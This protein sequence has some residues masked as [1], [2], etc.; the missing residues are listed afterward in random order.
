MA[1]RRIHPKARADLDAIWSYIA[2]DT[3]KSADAVIAQITAAFE[4]LT[5]N[6][7]A[8][9]PRPELSVSVRSFPV[10]SHVIFYVPNSEGI[11]I[12]RV[13]H[14]KQDITAADIKP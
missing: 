9:R 7:F 3:E 13:M 10:G 11:L 1:S 4:M 6:R 8:G 5:S 12:V 14:S 2:S